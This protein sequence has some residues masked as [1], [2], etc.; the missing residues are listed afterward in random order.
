M[1]MYGGYFDK[2]CELSSSD[3]M[4]NYS[5]IDPDYVERLQIRSIN[6]T[7][8]INLIYAIIR[9]CLLDI[10]Y[11][12]EGT[13][14]HR[15]ANQWVEDNSLHDFSFKWCLSHVLSAPLTALYLKRI[16]ERI[17]GGMLT[18]KDVAYMCSGVGWSDTARGTYRKGIKRVKKTR[19]M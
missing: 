15:L 8:E 17:L 2:G 10:L 6:S 1:G 11:C 13:A 18:D 7:P 16:R 9:N 12:Q 5:N 14:Q 4:G 19:R 3:K